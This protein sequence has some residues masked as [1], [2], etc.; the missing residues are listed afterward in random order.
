MRFA[1]EEQPGG[2]TALEVG[3]QRRDPC[4]IE[5]L[6]LRGATR[7]AFEVGRV[8]RVGEHEAAALDGR[9]V[10]PRPIGERFLAETGD[11]GFSVFGFAP[12]RQHAAGI[13]RA[14]AGAEAGAPFNDR[15]LGSTL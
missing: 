10:V 14:G 6:M 13:A 1:G 4:R 2:E 9:G 7:E 11:E 12:G 15:D 5:P 3:L 8:A